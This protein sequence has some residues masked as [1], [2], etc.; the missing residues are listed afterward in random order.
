LKDELLDGNLMYTDE[1]GTKFS[2][3]NMHFKN[4]SN[5][6]T[7]LYKAHTCKGH[8]PIHHTAR[9]RSKTARADTNPNIP[10]IDIRISLMISFST[11]S[12]KYP[13]SRSSRYPAAKNTAKR[14]SS[15]K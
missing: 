5:E 1:T 4:Y 12:G 11:L 8:A 9:F 2:G 13:K 7:V 6:K 15:G 14:R 3:K 10:T